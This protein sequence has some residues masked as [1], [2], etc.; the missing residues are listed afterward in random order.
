MSLEAVRVVLVNT[1]HPGNIGS[2]ARAM[3]TM[4]LSALYLVEPA[5][6][7]SDEAVMLA[8]GADD[9]LQKAVVVNTLEES[10]ADC[11]FAVGASAR[12]RGVSLPLAG[13]AESMSLALHESQRHPVALVFGREDRGLT[14]DELRQCHHQVHIPSVEGFSSLNLASAVQV[15]AYELR[16][17]S[18][19]LSLDV[20]EPKVSGHPLASVSDM[21]YFYA[22]LQSVLN[23]VGFFESSN[24]EKVMEKLRRL[25]GRARPDRVEM[26]ILRGILTETQVQMKKN[27]GKV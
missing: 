22:H 27:E 7:P 18:L 15:L 20:V 6:F 11:A 16:K 26:S 8:S 1:K 3:K 21:E 5:V 19:A 10:L 25:Y 12:V 23:E 9:I 17:A 4:G 24:A 2:A 13:P 14:N